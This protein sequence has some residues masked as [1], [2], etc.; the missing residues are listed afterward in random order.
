M[1]NGDSVQIA[2]DPDGDGGDG[3]Y[4]E[5][6][7]E[8]GFALCGRGPPNQ[9]PRVQA[10]RWVRDG[11]WVHERLPEQVIV[12][13]V[14]NETKRTK[15]TTYEAAI[16][17]SEL[18]IDPAKS[19]S[20]GFNL[21]VLDLDLDAGGAAAADSRVSGMALTPG[22]WLPKSPGSFARVELEAR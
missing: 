5:R 9:K 19:R 7:S 2:V 22:I 12:R 3:A 16:P 6:D 10:F 4:G 17:W 20:F 11:H 1:W 14:R 13:I 15:T 21:A 8:F 18:G